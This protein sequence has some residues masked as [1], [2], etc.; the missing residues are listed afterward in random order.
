MNVQT[1]I[2][3]VSD[4]G[5]GFITMVA[6]GVPLNITSDNMGFA[7]AIE[8]FNESN[9]AKLFDLMSPEMAVKAFFLEYGD[10][11]VENGCVCFRD[12]QVHSTLVDRILRLIG[13]ENV[14]DALPFVKFLGR[15]Q[16][17]PS[18]RAVDELYTFLEHEG[19]P[20]TSNGCFL[21]YK[22]I[23]NDFKDVYSGTFTN[24]VG[25]INEI[26]RNEVDDNF[27]IGCSYGLHVGTYSYAKGYMPSDGH[28]ML[29]EVDP[30]DVVSIPSDSSY[31]K[32]RVCKYKV[33][34]IY[35][36]QNPLP[37]EVY[38]SRYDAMDV[39]VNYCG[40]DD[41]GED[42][43]FL[44]GTESEYCT[45]DSEEVESATDGIVVELDRWNRLTIP[46]ELIDQFGRDDWFLLFVGYSSDGTIKIGRACDDSG[47]SYSGY[48]RKVFRFRVL[49]DTICD[50]RKYSLKFIEE[51]VVATPVK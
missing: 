5:V 15:L 42:E 24:S 38:D 9:W 29:V 26:P 49:K 7:K 48:A 35:T 8:A 20:I 45:A 3:N 1:L 47:Y 43:D 39:D 46:Q 31:Q 11:K 32:A 13:E 17:N 51:C 41:C 50:S 44:E 33:V 25:T 10:V 36:E 22:A 34:E 16:N 6:D 21:A 2:K 37:K 14:E 30:A 28:L 18:K 19:L 23:R 27:Q 40:N 12:K 4:D